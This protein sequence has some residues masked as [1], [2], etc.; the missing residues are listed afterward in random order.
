MTQNKYLIF[1]CSFIMMFLFLH[2][3][4]YR[5]ISDDIWFAKKAIEEPDHLKWVISRYYDWS[6]RSL[7]NM[8]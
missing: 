8:R 4:E 5:H 1:L 2:V 6:S 7:S 3:N